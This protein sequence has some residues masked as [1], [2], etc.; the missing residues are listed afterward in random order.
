MG[1]RQ[2]LAPALEIEAREEKKPMFINQC[3]SNQSQPV[4]KSMLLQQP[5]SGYLVGL[6]CHLPYVLRLESA[7]LY[8]VGKNTPGGLR[9]VASIGRQ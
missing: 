3:K 8:E 1:P 7:H 9:T 5:I 4:R 6:P 2:G